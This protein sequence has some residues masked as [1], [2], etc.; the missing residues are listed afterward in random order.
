MFEFQSWLGPRGWGL[1]AFFFLF[2]AVYRDTLFTHKWQLAS[3]QHSHGH[4]TH[5]WAFKFVQES[6]RY[7]GIISMTLRAAERETGVNFH[8][9]ILLFPPSSPSYFCFWCLNYYFRYGGGRAWR[10]QPCG[11]YKSCSIVSSS[12]PTFAPIYSMLRFVDSSESWPKLALEFLHWSFYHRVLKPYTLCTGHNKSSKNWIGSVVGFPKF[13][14]D[15]LT[16]EM[17]Y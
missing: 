15:A 1:Y 8:M 9:Q 17:K 16:K 3:L 10:R 7:T 14:S 4:D 12:T 6:V 2:C 11:N 5:L 13:I